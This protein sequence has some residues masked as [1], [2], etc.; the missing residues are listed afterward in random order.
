MDVV[1]HTTSYLFFFLSVFKKNVLSTNLSIVSLIFFSLVKFLNTSSIFSL[2]SP[3]LFF[4]HFFLSS[5]LSSFF[6]FSCFCIRPQHPHLPPK[7]PSMWTHKSYFTWL[8]SIK[9]SI[10]HK[11]V[12]AFLFMC[13]A[14]LFMCQA[15]NRVGKIN[16]RYYSF[17]RTLD[18]FIE[19][20]IIRKC[21]RNI[22]FV[23]LS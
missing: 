17:S 10:F 21:L 9:I 3:S 2:P 19:P 22:Y 12:D 6:I 18:I 14:F 15:Q 1:F 8:T 23:I 4:L 16:L 11:T 5:F 20:T 7:L 13:H